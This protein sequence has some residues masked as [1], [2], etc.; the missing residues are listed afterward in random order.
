MS[1]SG[2]RQDD[3]LGTGG[4]SGT[5]GTSGAGAGWCDGDVAVVAGVGCSPSN[6]GKVSDGSLCSC[7]GEGDLG[8]EVGVGVDGV[9]VGEDGV[10]GSGGGSSTG[11]M[12]AESGSGGVVG[13]L[14]DDGDGCGDEYGGV[15][16]AKGERRRLDS[17]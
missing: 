8:G 10:D 5:G 15:Q 12:S 13:R 17:S 1:S 9:S 16:Q 11:G 7:S 4:I 6:G 2:G 3:I 14:V